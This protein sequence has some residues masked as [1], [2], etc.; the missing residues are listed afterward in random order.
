LGRLQARPLFIEVGGTIATNTVW[1]KANSPYVVT[2]S[3][4]VADGVVLTIE[5]GVL[6][7]F[8]QNT[9]LY[10][11]GNGQL[12]AVG[13]GAEPIVFTSLRDDSQGGDTNGDGAATV[14]QPGDWYSISGYGIL[15]TLRIE[16]GLVRYTHSVEANGHLHLLDS[17]VEQSS[18][19][20]LYIY[21]NSGTA[22]TINVERTKLHAVNRHGIYLYTHPGTT[23]NL[24]NNTIDVLGYGT[25]ILLTNVAGAQI[26]DNTIH[27]ADDNEGAR[28]IV[29]NGVGETLSLTNNTLTRAAEGNAYAGI[30]VSN[31]RP[32]LTGNYVHGF[33]VAVLLNGGYPELSPVYS[34]NDFSQNKYA[35]SIAVAG[36][37]R[38]GSWTN[39]GGYLHFVRQTVT[40]KDNATLTIQPGSVIKFSTSGSLRLGEK[41]QLIAHGTM[42]ETIV[43]T[44]L[45][46]DAYSGDTNGDGGTAA[47]P[48][49]ME[50]SRFPSWATGTA[51]RATATFRWSI[52][53]MCCSAFPTKPL[54]GVAM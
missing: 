4:Y 10:A 23:I 37:L 18:G 13:T 44:S 24:R 34:G 40:I 6:V 7:K 36:E 50:V 54:M 51:S 26:A 49:A 29:L 9:G 27:V 53:R 33:E 45:Q 48:M 5:P 46:D 3:I 11:Q 28:G 22:P 39:V 1:T 16:H 30:E 52:W 15:S 14:P 25:G 21:P 20:C 8:T 38:S 12:L 43:F 2:T 47:I 35:N 41:S 19:D 17:T 32:Q 42:T 31:A